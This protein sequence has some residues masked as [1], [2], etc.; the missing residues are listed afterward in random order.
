MSIID[1]LAVA[2]IDLKTLLKDVDA[3]RL[4]QGYIDELELMFKHHGTTY[5]IVSITNHSDATEDDYE[6]DSYVS[7][8]ET[9]KLM[10]TE[11]WSTLTI[12]FRKMT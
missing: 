6:T 2:G 7:V 9:M 10:T 8:S 11:S 12:T 5:N 3:D 1:S 4:V